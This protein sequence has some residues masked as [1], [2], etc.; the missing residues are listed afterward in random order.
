MV[1]LRARAAALAAMT[2]VLAGSAGAET[3]GPNSGLPVPRFE[4]LSAGVANGRRGPSAEQPIL[5]VYRKRGLPLRVEAESGDWRRVRD[6]DGAVVWM[7][8]QV[9]GGP[10]SAYVLGAADD[11]PTPLLARPGAVRRP[12]AYLNHGVVA[13]VERCEEGWVRLKIGEVT[14]W[15]RA[16]QVWG[17]AC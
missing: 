7:H 3:I 12:V 9:L 2:I 5:W 6:P 14:G 1:A 13:R 15:T 8:R 4:S 10:P 11:L 16:S 17:A